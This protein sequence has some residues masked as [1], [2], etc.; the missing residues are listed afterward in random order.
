M[1]KFG[2]KNLKS[3]QNPYVAIWPFSQSTTLKFFR[4]IFFQG[5]PVDCE[6]CSTEVGLQLM[7]ITNSDPQCIGYSARCI[8]RIVVGHCIWGWKSSNSVYSE[9]YCRLLQTTPKMGLCPMEFDTIKC[10]F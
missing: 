3:P 10:T 5:H 7:N 1:M 4:V 9:L 2:H 6:L 8:L